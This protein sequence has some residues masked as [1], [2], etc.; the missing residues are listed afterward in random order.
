MLK[1]LSK[2]FISFG[3]SCSLLAT[4]ALCQN[5]DSTT[6]SNSGEEC[7]DQPALIDFD[8]GNVKGQVHPKTTVSSVYGMLTQ[9]KIIFGD[10]VALVLPGIQG[11]FILSRRANDKELAQK[12]SL[13]SVQE[14]FKIKPFD[15]MWFVP[16]SAKQL[17]VQPRDIPKSLPTNTDKTAIDDLFKTLSN[18]I[19]KPP[20][21]K[22]T[23]HNFAL[24]TEIE[25]GK[26]EP[27]LNDAPPGLYV[28]TGGDRAFRA[29]ALLDGLPGY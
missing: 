4:F 22:S 25:L 17:H 24:T 5:G 11:Q 15:G 29:A 18:N 13:C 9:N 8:V 12:S 16:V 23:K 20:Q 14:D 19:K 2:N 26:I 28:T 10:D 27:L 21:N 7:L 6:K 1:S 3:L